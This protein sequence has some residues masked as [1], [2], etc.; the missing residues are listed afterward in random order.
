MEVC[1]TGTGSLVPVRMNSLRCLLGEGL[2][3]VLGIPSNL[4]GCHSSC[5]RG[6]SGS[7]ECGLLPGAVCQQLCAHVGSVGFVCLRLLSC[8]PSC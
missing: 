3:G 8:V 7:G 1:G 6:K 2:L 4:F 5:C